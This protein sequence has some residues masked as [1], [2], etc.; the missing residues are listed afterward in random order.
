MG[1]GRDLRWIKIKWITMLKLYNSLGKSIQTFRPVNKKKVLVF[2][3][4]PSIYQ[5]AHIGN[6]RTFL[7]EDILVRYLEYSDYKVKRCMNFTDIEDKA[8]TEARQK[9]TSVKQLTDKNI[10]GFIRE[11]KTLRIKIPDHMPRASESIYQTV[12]IIENLLKKNIAYR[13]KG[14]VYFDPLKFPGFGK[15]YGLD[16]SKWPRRKIRFHRD[17]YPGM[18]W[19]LGDFILWHGIKRGD[20]VYWD[21]KI[22][23]GRPAWNVQDPGM[24]KKCFDG[25]LSIVCGGIDNLIRHHDYILAILESLNSY[26]AAEFWL[27]CNHVYVSGQKMSKSKGNIYYTDMLLKKGYSMKELRFFLIY[28]HY[29]KKINFTEQNIQASAVKLRAFLQ[30]VRK[31]KRRAWHTSGIDSQISKEIRNIFSKNMDADLNVKKAFDGIYDMLCTIMISEILPST[32]AGILK[33][34]KETNEV[35]KII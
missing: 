4:G 1:N 32:A 22:G 2:T 5:R 23:K 16:M 18:R 9:K 19:N 13:H 6:F 14:N 25:P 15:L 27:H 21:T 3:C 31:L 34:I 24:I 29:R 20:E 11:M 10:G 26:P 33:S 12:N 17:T 28:E 8:I 35:L 30:I 7:F